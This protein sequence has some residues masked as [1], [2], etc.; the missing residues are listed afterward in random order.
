[1]SDAPATMA[2]SDSLPP[3]LDFM[4]LL[5]SA[6]GGSVDAIIFLA[7]GVLTAAQTGNTILLA[8]SLAQGRLATGLHATVS[9]VAYV[10]GAA[11]G[12]FVI[13]ECHNGTSR[14]SPAGRALT[15]ELVPLGCLLIVWHQVGHYPSTEITA[16]LVALAAV[17]M[18]MQSAA[19][20]RLDVGPK[21]TYMTGTLTRFMTKTI[22]SLHLIASAEPQPYWERE[23]GHP[24]IYGVSWFVYAG[25]AAAGALLFLRFAET[26]LLLPLGAILA[27]VLAG[28][29]R[30]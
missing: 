14:L 2:P 21:T 19:V 15:T 11:V 30:R 26:A 29:Y 8:V 13:V 3:R 10:I 18:G 4:I 22:R 9:V 24:W 5:L 27:V 16:I 23:R 20:L 28:S 1:M 7:F 17:G 25:G 12:E 6:A